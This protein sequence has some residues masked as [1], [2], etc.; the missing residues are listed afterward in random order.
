MVPHVN[1]HQGIAQKLQEKRENYYNPGL[2]KKVKSEFSSCHDCIMD[3]RI[4]NTQISP[5]KLCL[6]EWG[7]GSKMPRKLI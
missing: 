3:K 4:D 7:M 6:I 2:L 1:T 5:E